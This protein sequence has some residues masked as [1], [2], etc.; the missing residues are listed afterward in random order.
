MRPT[1]PGSA[2]VE[3]R[4]GPASLSTAVA[5]FAPAADRHAE[6]LI[7]GSM[8]GVASLVARRYY[9]HPRNVFWPIMARLFGFDPLDPYKARLA[10]LAGARIALWDVLRSCDRVG[11]LDVAIGR[12]VP[13]DFAA[14][15]GSHQRIRQVLFNGTKAEALFRRLVLPSVALLP[16][17]YTRLPSTSPANASQSFDRRFEAWRAVS[18]ASGNLPARGRSASR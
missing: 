15:L 2:R 3:G 4:P 16:I 8:P 18:G 17:A 6:I 9:A 10:H 1:R 14:F 5:S 7:L 13:N 11:S 12:P